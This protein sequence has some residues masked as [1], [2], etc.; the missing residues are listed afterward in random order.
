MG[1]GNGGLM[2]DAEGNARSFKSFPERFG[3]TYMADGECKTAG[4]GRGR[5]GRELGGKG[6]GGEDH[7]QLLVVC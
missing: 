3:P 7:T 1:A 2:G 6:G 4:V 5:A